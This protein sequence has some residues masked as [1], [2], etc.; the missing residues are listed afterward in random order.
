MLFFLNG[1]ADDPMFERELE[2]ALYS[3]GFTEA[4]LSS[5]CK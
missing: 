5:V 1:I 4:D 2:D 3:T